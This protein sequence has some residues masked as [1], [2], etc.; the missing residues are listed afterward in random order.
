MRRDDPRDGLMAEWIPREEQR[1]QSGRKRA[2]KEALRQRK[3]QPHIDHMG[4]DVNEMKR[5]GVVRALE[6]SQ[7][8]PE[9]EGKRPIVQIALRGREDLQQR[10]VTRQPNVDRIDPEEGI[11][12]RRGVHQQRGDR[13]EDQPAE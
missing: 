12:Q 13:E 4:Q 3:H 8:F 6:R 1:G 5:E 2:L 7:Q 9:R 10:A 11:A